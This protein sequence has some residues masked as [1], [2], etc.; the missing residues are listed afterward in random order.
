MTWLASQGPSKHDLEMG[1]VPAQDSSRTATLDPAALPQLPPPT[2]S[3]HLKV[4]VEEISGSSDSTEIPCSNPECSENIPVLASLNFST[5]EVCY[6]VT[7]YTCKRQWCREHPCDAITR[8]PTTIQMTS[9]SQQ[10]SA[11]KMSKRTIVG[12]ICFCLAGSA[13]I[14]GIICYM[15]G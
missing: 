15:A 3:V 6:Q 1:I 8:A 7:C 5:C 9:P 12:M 2:Y 13:L 11:A 14:L 4:Q 10:G